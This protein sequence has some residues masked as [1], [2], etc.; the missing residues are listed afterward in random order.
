[1]NRNFRIKKFVTLEASEFRNNFYSAINNRC[2]RID[3]MVDSYIIMRKQFRSINENY[4]NGFMNTR[5][6]KYVFGFDL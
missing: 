4:A 1:L 2:K 5:E 6:K 3:K